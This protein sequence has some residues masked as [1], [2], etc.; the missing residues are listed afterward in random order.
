M[1]HKALIAPGSYLT[2]SITS[3]FHYFFL[4]SELW[5]LSPSLGSLD[6]PCSLSCRKLIQMLLSGIISF[7]NSLTAPQCY[8]LSS[9]R[10]QFKCHCLQEAFS[11]F[12]YHT[13]HSPIPWSYP[14]YKYSFTYMI[15]TLT[16]V[17]PPDISYK[18]RNIFI[19]SRR[20]RQCVCVQI[21]SLHSAQLAEIY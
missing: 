17:S 1:A 13:I 16:S 6:N 8:S 4:A 12:S 19:R 7:L 14:S 9:F 20:G 10:S 18:W 11:G 15:L 2:N 3:L 5:Q 21:L